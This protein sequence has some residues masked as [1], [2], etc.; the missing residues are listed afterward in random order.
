METPEIT[1]SSNGTNSDSFVNMSRLS[2]HILTTEEGC[3]TDP[4][5]DNRDAANQHIKRIVG[6]TILMGDGLYFDL[7]APNA[8]GMTIEDYA[9]GIA[10]NI[11]FRGQTKQKNG[12]RCA[13]NVAQH[14]VMLADQMLDDGCTYE[15]AFEGL[16]HES[17]EVPWPD[18]LGPGKALFP[19]EVR[20]LIKRSG[21]AINQHFGVTAKHKS[22]VKRYDIRMLATEKRELMPHSG[23]DQWSFTEGYEP[24]DFGI[25]PWGIDY[26]AERFIACYN[27]LAPRARIE[28]EAA[29]V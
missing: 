10:T 22:L 1:A 3:Q 8:E 26:A 12:L 18:F 16:M 4:A 13:Y 15:Q 27:F 25:I 2:D 11:R 9:W 23:V 21:H 6:P 5:L 7:Q 19:P 20:A 28:A 17:D 29:N 14:V 24:F